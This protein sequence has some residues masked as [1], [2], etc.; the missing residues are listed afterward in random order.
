MKIYL[1]VRKNSERM[2]IICQ[3]KFGNPKQLGN[4]FM[5]DDLKELI[6]L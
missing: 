6:E 2:L 4:P 1:L 5:V 3:K